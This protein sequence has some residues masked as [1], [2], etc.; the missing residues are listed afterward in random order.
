MVLRQHETTQLGPKM[1]DHAGWQCSQHDRSIR[2]DPS[3]PPVA[4]RLGT[5]HDVLHHEHLVAFETRA[6]WH[7]RLDYPILDGDPWHD[8]PAPPAFGPLAGQLRLTRVLHAAWLDPRSTV[9]TFQ[10]RVLFPQLCNQPPLL[11][12]LAQQP[13]H[14]CLQRFE[15]KAINVS[16]RGHSQVESTPPASA[17]AISQPAPQALP[18]LQHMWVKPR[19]SKV[20]GL[21]SPCPARSRAA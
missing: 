13:H 9:Q 4:Y 6:W 3:L 21:P 16:R 5:Q 1:S 17:Q 11:T 12:D 19:K 7:L 2:R 15:R 18:L 8:L 20:F 10:S 14:K